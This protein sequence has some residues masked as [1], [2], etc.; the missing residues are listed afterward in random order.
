LDILDSPSEEAFDRITRLAQKLFDV[1]I[2]I[3]SF[4]DGHRQWYK[5]HQGLKTSEVPRGDSFCRYVMAYGAPL[6]VPDAR[7]DP[8]F[9]QNPY[10]RTDLG[11]CFYAGFP[12]QMSDGN[13]LGTLCLVDVKPRQFGSDQLEIM[14]DLAHIIVN[15]LQLRLCADKDSL[16]GVYTRRAF[17]DEARR[18][19]ALALRHH[20]PLSVISLDL[21][22]FKH[23]NDTLGHAAGD[24]V[25]VRTVAG[26]SAQLRESD[27][28]GRLGGE[29]F[30]ILLPGTDQTGA[31]EVAEKL[32]LAIE[33]NEIPIDKK[34]IKATASFGVAAMNSSARDMETLLEQADKA[35][36]EAKAAGR[37]RVATWHSLP[38]REAQLNAAG[39]LKPDK[40]FSMA[41]RPPWIALSAGF[42]KTAPA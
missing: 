39:S 37:N 28:I 18:M 31:M 15:E 9:S 13:S 12:L 21:D 11:V 26:C 22:Y 6:V 30:S 29:E 10:V 20:R 36:Y 16:T 5:S 19:V 4:I 3:V 17:K 40:F 32:R 25:L 8:R 38:P 35:L 7:V 23:T 33:A 2:A 27:V 42:H 24:Q 34:T 14:S 41:A 1:P